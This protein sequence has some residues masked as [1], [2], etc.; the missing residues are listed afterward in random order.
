MSGNE[1]AVLAAQDVIFGLRD[2]GF[3]IID[4]VEEADAIALFSIATVRHDPLAGWIADKAL[5]IFKENRTG[6]VICSIKAETQIV[7]PTINTLV[8][9]IVSEVRRYY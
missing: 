8:N 5:L 4:K 9:G 6:A 1:Q 7:T 3:E 2:I